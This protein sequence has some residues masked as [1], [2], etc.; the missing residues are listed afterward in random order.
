MMRRQ[1]Q[2]SRRGANLAAARAVKAQRDAE[3]IGRT[4]RRDERIP[5]SLAQHIIRETLASDASLASLQRRAEQRERGAAFTLSAFERRYNALQGA[6]RGI[7][8]AMREDNARPTTTRL[9][10]PETADRTPDQ[11]RRTIQAPTSGI[12]RLA[13]RETLVRYGAAAAAEYSRQHGASWRYPRS[14]ADRIVPTARPDV[15][16]TT[17]TADRQAIA[18]G[19]A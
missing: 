8:A 19:I 18:D 3:R 17:T 15:V 9:T 6:H 16:L 14:A 11:W 1:T 5:V 4:L 13:W 10:W 7:V 2:K 12:A